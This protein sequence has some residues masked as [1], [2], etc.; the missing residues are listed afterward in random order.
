MTQLLRVLARLLRGIAAP[1]LILEVSFKILDSEVSADLAFT[2][3]GNFALTWALCSILSLLIV[4]NLS[5]FSSLSLSSLFSWPSTSYKSWAWVDSLVRNLCTI[6]H[7]S[8]QFESRSSKKYVF[9][10]KGL[11]H[12]LAHFHLVVLRPHLLY[13]EVFPSTWLHS[14][15]CSHLQLPPLIHFTSK[16]SPKSSSRGACSPFG[17]HFF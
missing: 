17:I 14:D 8:L 4:S 13:Y 3:I 11:I 9:N 12:F 6:E 2:F 1:V 10:Y 7:Q 16:L 15:L 5:S